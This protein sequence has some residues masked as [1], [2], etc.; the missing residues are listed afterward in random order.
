MRMATAKKTGNIGAD[1][2]GE[3][4]ELRLCWCRDYKMVQLLW[5]TIWQF[6]THTSL[7]Y[8]PVILLLGTKRKENLPPKTCMRMFRA[9]VFITAKTWRRLWDHQPEQRESGVH[10]C[11]AN[12]YGPVQQRK[13]ALESKSTYYMPFFYEILEQVQLT[14]RDRTQI[15]L[16][17]EVREDWLQRDTR[18]LSGACGTYS[19]SRLAVVTKA[20]MFVA[21][22]SRDRYIFFWSNC[23]SIKLI[24]IHLHLFPPTPMGSF[25]QGFSKY[26][27]W[28]I[29]FS[30]TRKAGRNLPYWIRISGRGGGGVKYARHWRLFHHW[31]AIWMDP[32]GCWTHPCQW[33]VPT[34]PWPQPA[35]G[36][37]PWWHMALTHQQLVVP[38]GKR[39]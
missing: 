31:P 6:L 15:H 5:E 16:G 38:G 9:A 30:I 26:G 10:L 17:L 11:R 20:A 34:A 13:R 29:C 23:I 19:V 2:D 28:I 33:P 39:D 35:L 21:K 7:P 4:R 3:W 24:K 8:N 27:F 12:S 25:R 22:Y 18:E 14:C 32:R 1:E 37:A 36:A